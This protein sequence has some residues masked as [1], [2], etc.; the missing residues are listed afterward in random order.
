MLCHLLFLLQSPAL[1]AFGNSHFLS[2]PLDLWDSV[3]VADKLAGKEGK[4]R[5][6]LSCLFLWCHKVL[7]QS[8]YSRAKC[9]KFFSSSYIQIPCIV[10]IINFK[11]IYDVFI[12]LYLQVSPSNEVPSVMKFCSSEI[13]NFFYSFFFNFLRKETENNCDHTAEAYLVF[14]S[15][16]IVFSSFTEKI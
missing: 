3:L 2:K 16:L 6:G 12:Y 11:N 7:I 1:L 14:P 13:R 15:S 5:E 8:P 4:E 10:H 9:Y